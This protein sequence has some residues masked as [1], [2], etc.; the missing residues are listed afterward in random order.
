MTNVVAI[1]PARGGSKGIPRKNILELAG[2]P[3]IAYSII[4]AKCSQYVDRVIVTTDDQEISEISQRYGAEVIVRPDELSDDII[5]PDASI[6]HSIEYLKK[7]EEYIPDCIVFLQPTSPIRLYSDIDAAID[8]FLEKQVDTVFS[9][10]D[11]HPLIWGGR[12]LSVAPINYDPSKRPRRQ[13]YESLLIE[14]GS[15]Y[16]SKRSVYE[17]KKDR[18]GN[19]VHAYIM[20]NYTLLQIDEFDDIAIVES[21]L[22]NLKRQ[23]VNIIYG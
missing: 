9:A 10:V 1:I 22:V 21:L 6:V 23:G 2:L 19:L 14:N 5:M 13:D 3:L 17:E 20:N 4:A 16:V 12:G 15:I 8:I 11:I 18:F 7:T